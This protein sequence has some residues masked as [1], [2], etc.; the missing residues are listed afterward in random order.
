MLPSALNADMPSSCIFFLATS[1][2]VVRLSIICLKAVPPSCAFIPLS[3]SIPRAVLSS[4]VPPLSILAVPPTV[5]IASPN[6]ATSV[7]DFCAVFASLSEN[8]LSSEV[9]IPRAD[10]LLVTMLDAS[11]SSMPPADARLRATGN[12]EICLSASYPA[13]AR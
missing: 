13:R 1:V 9:E 12:A 3:A 7:F 6:C 11:A 10:I 8:P 2:G 4:V 5:I